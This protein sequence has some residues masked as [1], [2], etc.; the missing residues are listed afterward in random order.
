VTD[1]VES[2]ETVVV[3][4]GQA[5]LSVSRCLR[6]CGHEHVVLE[7]GLVGETWRSERWDS[8]RLNTPCFW[9]QLPGHEYR[10]DDR[11]A[12]LTRG[13]TVAYLERYA[14]SIG[15]TIRTGVEARSLRRDAD[16]GFRLET[17]DGTYRA[18]KVVVA[19]GSFRCPTAR[20]TGDV[21]GLIQLHASDYCNPEQLPDGGVIVVGSGQSGCQIAAE[22][23]R[24]GRDVHL[25]VGRCPSL[26]FWYR[27]RTI[28]DWLVDAGVADDTVDTLPSPAARLSC[29]PT[30]AST[31]MPH[32]VG[33]RRLAREG[34]TLVGR[35]LALED[36]RAKF[37]EDANRRLAEGDDFVATI[38]ERFDEH[39]LAS[40]LE[41]PADDAEREEPR[42]VPELAELDLRAAG[43]GTIIWANGWRPDYGW[44]ELPIFDEHGW[45]R[46]SQ[47]VAEE[48]GLYFV[49]LHWLRKRKSA[50]LLGVAEDAE[51]VAS[52]VTERGE[53]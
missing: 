33:P 47:G 40:G 42:G 12:F 6:Q 11:D 10:G 53:A 41:L 18:A 9:L 16:G 50:L 5:G 46:Q 19:S 45:P 15:G 2:I 17:S 27:G 52:A 21:A 3:G 24:A 32:L 49:G 4:A 35:L 20:A 34:V 39:A 1:V 13:E 44:I 31:H 37:A 38:A 29:N 25:S 8:F 36:G 23:N 30:V 14:E 48:P 22:L 28:Y 43:V 7:R 51:L 26:P